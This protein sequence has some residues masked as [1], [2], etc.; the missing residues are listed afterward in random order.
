MAAVEGPDTF[1]QLPIDLDTATT[2]LKTPLTTDLRLTRE[3]AELNSLHRSIL[4]ETETSDATKQPP[5]NGVPAHPAN[6]P[7]KRSAQ[8]TKL[9]EAGNSA[10]KKGHH[11]DAARMYGLAIEMASQRPLWE[12]WALVREELAGLYANRAQARISLSEWAEAGEDA[13]VSV[14]MKRALNVKAWYRRGVCLRE[15]GR[16]DEAREWVAQGVEFESAVP[17]GAKAADELRELAREID[18][19][20]DA[21]RKRS[22]VAQTS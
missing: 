22:S 6:V 12:P 5:T 15:M 3:L 9:R 17:N 21:V 16:L 7:P 8:V 11:G 13:R 18:G 2:T 10:F 14:E 19:L 4:R 20:I 1:I